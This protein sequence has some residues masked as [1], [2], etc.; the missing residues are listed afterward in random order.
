[1]RRVVRPLIPALASALEAQNA[2]YEK[3]VARDAHL[4]ALRA[5]AAAV[6]TGQQ[7]GLFLG[8]LYTLYKAASTIRLAR[9][10]A[11]RWGSPVVPVFWLQTEDHDAAEISVCHVARGS[12]EPLSLTLAVSGD[13]VSVAHRV[14]PAAVEDL[15]AKL[16]DTLSRLP[17]GEEHVVCL[18]RH[19]HAGAGWGEAFAGVLATLFAQEGLVV[20]D[21]RDPTLAP[22]ASPVHR[23]ALI[24]ARPIARALAERVGALA[25]HG[26]RVAVH[27]REDA[28]LSFF[29]PDGPEGPRCRLAAADG[30]FVEVGRQR[31]RAL[32]EL[33][34][35]LDACPLAFSTS[36][37]LRPILQDTWL[38][39]AAYV[40]GPGEIAYFAQMAPLYTAFDVPM[41]IVVPRAQLRLLD[42]T[43]RR[44]LTRTGL[45][46]AAA[47][48]P[49]EEALTLARAGARGEPGGDHV[50][51]RLVLGID[52]AL[53]DIAPLLRQAGER[54]E[55]S[56]EKTRRTMARS[57]GKLGRN[58]DR[59][60]LL[61]NREVVDDVR[62]VQARLQPRGIPQERFFG[63]PSFAARYGQRAFI[64]R[65]L[66]KAEPLRVGIEDLEL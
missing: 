65:V 45:T 48:R 37:L 14:L 7:T 34:G 11:D 56:L 57:A 3:S 52:R 59:A 62:R 12:D 33:L 44:A 60:R 20:I 25:S 38:P 22:L 5:G 40:G 47:C 50:A 41:P 61:R 58:Y 23:R 53:A 32:A 54:A 9:W 29:H 19:Y 2:R 49:F 4:R 35:V 55:Q 27:V 36:A 16:R 18:A 31:T 13:A 24:E 28:P 26:F 64:E 1:M 6:V 66:S 17:H 39:T 63:L 43:T 46:P 8:P 51:E 42:D 15:L 10:L 30:G 21:P